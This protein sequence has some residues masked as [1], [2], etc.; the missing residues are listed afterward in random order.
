MTIYFLSLKGRRTTDSIAKLTS[1]KPR[2][3]SK[4]FK[5]SFQ[6]N[7]EHYLVWSSGA[8][9]LVWIKVQWGC[10]SNSANSPLV[11]RSKPQKISN[12]TKNLLAGRNLP[13]LRFWSASFSKQ[14]VIS[15]TLFFPWSEIRTVCRSEIPLSSG[16]FQVSSI[17]SMVTSKGRVLTNISFLLI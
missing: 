12:H 8:H 1:Q 6:L 5:N 3:L 13:G 4:Y 15:S 2:K 9:S 17:K 14:V 7:K 10:I 16:G 11:L